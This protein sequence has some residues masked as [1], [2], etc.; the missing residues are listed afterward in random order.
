MISCSPFGFEPMSKMMMSSMI[1]PTLSFDLSSPVLKT[2]SIV[3]FLF[4][5]AARS[6]PTLVKPAV[7]EGK[8][9][10]DWNT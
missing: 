10:S 6:I 7:N 8:S 3:T 9:S 1:Q 5:N 2:N 4:L